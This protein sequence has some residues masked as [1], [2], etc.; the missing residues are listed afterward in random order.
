MTEP[1]ISVIVPCYRVESS[2]AAC[3]GDLTAQ[4]YRNIEIIAVD[5]GSPDRTGDILDE[6][7]VKDDRIRVIHKENG[8]VGACRNTGLDNVTGELIAF[9]DPD[10]RVAPDFLSYLYTLLTEH[11]ADIAS[12]AA[13]NVI[14]VEARKEYHL[15]FPGV[16]VMDAKEALERMCYN[17]LFYITLWDKL[18]KKELFDGVRCVPGKVFEDTGT[19]YLAVAKA[20]KIVAGGEEKY[21]YI[22]RPGSITTKRFAMEKLDYVEM[23]DKMCDDIEAWYPDLKRA[24]NRKRGHAVFSTMTQLVNSRVRLPEVEKMLLARLKPLRG[25][26]LRDPKAPKRD[27]IGIL[28]S[29]GGFGLFSAVWRV[30][31][32][33]KKG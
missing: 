13:T 8:G 12:V 3:I 15:G 23:A 33:V 5:D 20:R 14:G 31:Y 16:L 29:Y 26:I 21:R 24:C 18:Y 2:V 7:A 25:G 9:V 27:K 1:K 6:C 30:Y 19:T 32:K 10:D 28:A 22:T 11:D 17:D 4:T